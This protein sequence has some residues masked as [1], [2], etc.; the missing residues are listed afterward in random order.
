[1]QVVWPLEF[2]F[3]E[4]QSVRGRGVSWHIC[5]ETC[6]CGYKVKLPKAELHG[7]IHLNIAAHMIVP[8]NDQHNVVFW[9]MQQHTCSVD[10]KERHSF[11]RSI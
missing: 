5:T 6:S 8:L 1:M 11:V 2:A 10:K 9:I 7:C 3:S 4:S